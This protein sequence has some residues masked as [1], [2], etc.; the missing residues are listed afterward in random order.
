MRWGKIADAGE[1]VITSRM[2]DGG[3]VFAD[4]IEQDHLDFDWGRGVRVGVAERR[5]HLVIDP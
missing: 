3:T 4:G 2:N 1:V 5:L